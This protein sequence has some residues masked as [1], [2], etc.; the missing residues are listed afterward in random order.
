M[1]SI[2]RLE[3]NALQPTEGDFCV[4][5]RVKRAQSCMKKNL[6]IKIISMTADFAM[7]FIHYIENNYVNVDFN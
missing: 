2:S 3:K 6:S 7:G 4:K 1:F 5:G